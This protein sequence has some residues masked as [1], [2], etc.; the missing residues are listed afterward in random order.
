MR[1]WS[2]REQAARSWC[3]PTRISRRTANPTRLAFYGMNYYNQ[4]P[5]AFDNAI[6]ICTPISVD[7]DSNL[8][9]RLPLQRGAAAGIPAGNSERAGAGRTLS[10]K[11]GTFVAATAAGGRPGIPRLSTIVLRPSRLTGRRCMW[12]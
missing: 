4:N 9:F 6:Q 12:R 7:N 1:R 8:V 2:F 3:G 11:T 5:Q 10:G